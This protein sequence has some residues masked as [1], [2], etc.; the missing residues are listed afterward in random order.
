MSQF[1]SNR[2]P[3]Y[4]PV[5]SRL[6]A[7]SVTVDPSIKDQDLELLLHR[8]LRRL[9][10]EVIAEGQ[11]VFADDD[12]TPEQYQERLGL[13]G[14]LAGAGPAGVRQRDGPRCAAPLP[15]LSH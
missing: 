3:R 2:A 6:E 11:A 14:D 9:E 7:L 8:S 5:L 10:S 1:V 13:P 4:R 15:G 12:S